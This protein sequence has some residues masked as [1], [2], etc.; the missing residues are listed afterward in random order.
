MPVKTIRR[1]HDIITGKDDLE[2]L[3]EFPSMSVHAGPSEMTAEHD[4]VVPQRWVISKSSGC[5]QLQNL[6][7]LD[8]L[9]R[10]AH[11]SGQT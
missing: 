9:Y 1:E 4:I 11:G 5:V 3:Y 8:I 2:P 7:P 10:Q 6:V